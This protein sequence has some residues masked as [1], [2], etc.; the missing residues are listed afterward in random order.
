VPDTIETLI[1]RN[2]REVFGERDGKKRREAIAQLWTE[3]CIFIDH[4][5]KSHGRDELDR[6]VAALHQRLPSYVSVSFGLSIFFT[7]AGAWLGAMDDRARSLNLLAHA[8]ERLHEELS[9]DYNDMIYPATREE[10]ERR[11]KAFIR[12]WWL[13]HRAVEDSLEEAGDRLFTFTRLPQSQWRSVRTT[14][15]IERLHEQFK[16]S[17]KTKTVL[18]SADTAALLFGALLASGQI[19]MR[20]V[21]GLQSLPTKPTSISRLT[22][23]LDAIPSVTRKRATRNSNHITAGTLLCTKAPS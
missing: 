23:Q 8:P 4:S 9:G 10:I 7:K 19:N 17:I 21:D 1:K 5:G 13:K 12:K 2:L 18:Q 3:D 20:K 22:S 6:A 11:R 14:N 16:R 15:A